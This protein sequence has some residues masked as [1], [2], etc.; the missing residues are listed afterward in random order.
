[1]NVNEVRK[2]ILELAQLYFKGATVT[3][4]R[5]SRIAKQ[6]VPL[7]TIYTGVVNRPL[8]PPTQIIDGVPVSYYPSSVTVQIDL[9]TKGRKVDTEEGSTPIMENTAVDDLAAFVS[10]LNSEYVVQYC[11]KKDISIVV[12]N[13]VQDLTGLIDDTNYEY[14]AMVEVT[15]NFT[16]RAIGITGTMSADG[17][18]A[19]TPSGGGNLGLLDVEGDYFE[20]VEINNKS[21]K[22]EHKK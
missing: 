18:I 1:M 11:N 6:G 16:T 22:E 21:V 15:V 9:F 19:Q 20:D 2:A 17:G 3:L 14:R 5:Q 10:F 8:Y 7:V 12:P 4:A 13:A